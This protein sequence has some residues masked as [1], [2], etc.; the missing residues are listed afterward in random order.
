MAKAKCWLMKSEPET[1]SF[2]DLVRS[3]GRTTHWE[4][5]RNYQARNLLRDE[6]KKGDRVFFY[7]SNTEEPAV[8]GIAQVVKEG[9]PDPFALDPK[10]PYFDEKAKAKGESPWSMVDVKATHRMETPVTL[11][12]MRG[13]KALAKMVLLKKGSRL[14]V[15]PVTEAEFEVICRL[16][17][18]RKL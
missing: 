14:S 5:V 15:Q 11:A 17:N 13:E 16:G 8:A 7:H 9:Y 1:F 6:I 3:P 4:G 2:E 12:Q 18:P 10:S